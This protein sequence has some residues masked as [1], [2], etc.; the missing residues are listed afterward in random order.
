MV[1]VVTNT[2]VAPLYL[3]KVVEALTKDNPNVS[4][5]R[6]ILPDDEKCKNMDTLMKVFDKAIG[7][8][9]LDQRCK[10]V[11]LGG[12]VIGTSVAMLLLLTFGVDSSV[13]S[14]TAINHSLGKNLI[15]AFYQPRCTL[16][17]TD[18]LNTLPD[19]ELASGL[20]EAI[21]CG[22]VRDA[23]F[24]EGQER[25]IQAIMAR[26][27]AAL[28]YA[29]KRSCEIEA[30]LAKETGVG[31]GNWLHGEAVAAGTSKLPIAPAES[32]MIEMFRPVM[33]VDKKVADGLLRLR[34]SER[35]FG[36]LSS[37]ANMIE[38]PSTK[39]SMHFGSADDPH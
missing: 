23:D 26:D 11:A 29:I 31:N 19:R 21:K 24:F 37:P 1:L 14:K 28:A 2:K 16:I 6:V 35:S 9:L 10:F 22:L 13:G 7:S 4:V 27:P 8:R 34:P 3:V 33:A 20:A 5:E 15:G 36:K 25:N 30:E 18:T 32:V 12:G 38:R 17:D 39:H